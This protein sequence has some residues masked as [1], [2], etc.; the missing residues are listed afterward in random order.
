LRQLGY[1]IGYQKLNA[2]DFGTPQNR[3]RLWLRAVRSDSIHTSRQLCLFGN[4]ELLPLCGQEKKISWWEA[5]AHLELELPIVTLNSCQIK[6][7]PRSLIAQLNRSELVLIGKEKNQAAS[8]KEP[9]F[10][11]T[12]TVNTV[13]LS[14]K[15]GRLRVATQVY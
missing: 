1:A 12:S 6:R 14:S 9:G 7:L 5:I 13:R 8:S 3:E 11:I 15:P 2:A 10:T 4:D